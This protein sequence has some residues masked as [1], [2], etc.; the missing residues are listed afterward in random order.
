MSALN[1][2]W[3]GVK[4]DY[5]IGRDDLSKAFYATRN[6]Q[7]LDDDAP[8]LVKMAAEHPLIFRTR[9]M[10][11]MADPAAVQARNEMGMGLKP[12][13]AGKAGQDRSSKGVDV[14]LS[15]MSARLVG[16]ASLPL[17]RLFGSR[18]Q[19]VRSVNAKCNDLTWSSMNM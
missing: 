9:E 19:S 7:E 8:R 13:T 1:E 6:K 10:L 2:F 5:G 4:A 16:S 12:T 17:P 14:H 3:E 15:P 18:S 11:G